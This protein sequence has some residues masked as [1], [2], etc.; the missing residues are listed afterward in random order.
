MTRFGISSEKV[1]AALLSSSSLPLIKEHPGSCFIF[2][3]VIQLPL[4]ATKMKLRVISALLL[5][6]S[7]TDAFA[8]VGRFSG[9]AVRPSQTARSFGVDP[10]SF[11]DISQHVDTFRDAFTSL[12]LSDV[13]T[14]VEGA[15]S[16]VA[17]A[18]SDT[19]AASSGSGWFGFLVGPIEGLLFLIHSSISAV[20]GEANSW[21]IS[22]V[23]LTILVKL[24]TFP[25]TKTQLE[26]TNKMQ[27]RL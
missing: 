18:A 21:G 13:E 19:A 25:L 5:S 16:S 1:V 17:D 22:I 14:A 6:L 23:L 24:L 9:S 20:A 27:V 8:P 15:A 2:P 7:C 10:S 11:Q 26:S 3:C 4:E 12:T